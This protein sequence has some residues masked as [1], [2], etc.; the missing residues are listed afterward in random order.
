MSVVFNSLKLIGINMVQTKALIS[1]TDAHADFVK[2][3][4]VIP[5]LQLLV[6]G[7]SDKIIRFWSA[8]VLASIFFLS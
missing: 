5:S 2:Y 7:S 1:S 4:F 8:F 3:L 6:S